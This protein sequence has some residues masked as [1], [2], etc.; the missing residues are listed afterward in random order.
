MIHTRTAGAKHV[1]LPKTCRRITEITTEKVIAENAG[2]F[3]IDLP[4]YCTA[5]FLL[6]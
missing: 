2:A 3:S 1:V 6:E 4:K 5:V